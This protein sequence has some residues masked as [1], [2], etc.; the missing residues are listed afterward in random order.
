MSQGCL[1]LP[2]KPMLEEANNLRYLVTYDTYIMSNIR[3]R[4]IMRL[5]KQFLVREKSAPKK[6]I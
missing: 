6:S 4:G 1:A 3:K 5:E 2:H